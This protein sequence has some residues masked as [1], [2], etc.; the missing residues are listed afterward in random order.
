MSNLSEM[1]DLIKST[2]LESLL[3]GG[4]WTIFAPLN[5]AFF[6][7]PVDLI[8]RDTVQFAGGVE[9]VE[10]VLLFHTYGEVI[11]DRQALPCVAGQNLLSSAIGKDSRTLC[12]KDI[13][14]HQKGAGN[15]DNAL[16]EIV[17]FDIAAC[18]G[19]IHIVDKVLLF[20]TLIDTAFSLSRGS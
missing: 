11:L 12:D 10:D 4:N 13:P 15:A 9:L 16:P 7:L 20:D 18:N 2:R 6:E 19:I 5:Q 1:C 14:T 8:Q 17:E 3:R